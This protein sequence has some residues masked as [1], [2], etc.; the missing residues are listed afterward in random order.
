MRLDLF[1]YKLPPELIAQKPVTPRDHSRLFVYDRQAEKIGHRHF[2]DLPEILAPGDVLVLNNT[3]VFPARL[4]GEKKISSGKVEVFLL[5]ELDKK[6]WQVLLRGRNMKAGLEIV[7]N[8]ELSGRIV[9]N[10]QDGT[11]TFSFNLFGKDFWRELD[12]IGQAPLPPYIKR[13]SSLDEYQTIFAKERGS[14]AAPT[15]GL[16]FTKNLIMSLE[17]SGIEIK[18]VTLH[19]GLGTFAPVKTEEIERHKMHAEWAYLDRQTAQ[20]LNEARREKRRIIGVGTTSVR[21]LESF[22]DDFGEL[23]PQAKWVD[24]FIYPGYTFKFIDSMI[25]N[26]HLPKSTLLMLLA[27]FLAQ[28][29]K[30]QEGIK[31]FQRLYQE[32]IKEKY[33]FYSYG[34]AMF[35]I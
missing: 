29:K 35:I 14:V 26:F 30:P 34:D 3:K 1:D 11:W 7:F 28:N 27:A 25:T 18:Y 8:K 9:K 4:K 2:F 22:C 20:E 12:K 5:R 23:T 33:R 32:A 31:I 19:V 21:T 17:E 24:T 6:E 13:P 16:H 10:N 15:A